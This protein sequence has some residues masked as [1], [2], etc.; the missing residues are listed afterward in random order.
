M[1]ETTTTEQPLRG[2]GGKRPGA[3]RPKGARNKFTEAILSNSAAS[4]ELPLEYM[5]R[6]M[7][8]PTVD[9][10]RRDKMAIAVAPY[11]HPRKNETSLSGTGIT[12]NVTP[13]DASV[14]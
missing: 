8:D 6:I 2:H 10:D 5:L 14:G 1:S 9:E 12:V 11:M 13:F 3:G 4:G 7:R